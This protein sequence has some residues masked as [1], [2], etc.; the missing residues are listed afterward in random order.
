MQEAFGLQTELLTVSFIVHNDFSHIGAALDSLYQTTTM[1]M[2]VYLTINSGA[3]AEVE[4]IRAT[5]PQVQ[6]R[7]NAQPIGFAANHNAIMRLARTPF[8][9]LVNDDVTFQPQALDRLVGYLEAHADAGLVGPRVLN[10]DGSMQLSTFSDPA[11][12]RMLFH[13]SGLGKFT[14]HGG[15]FR[16]FLQR[17]GIARLLRV[18]SLNREPTTRDVPVI[19]GVCMVARR[20]AFLQAG[21]MDEVT[22]VYGEEMGWHW[23]LR[24]HG[25]RVV[26]LPSACVTHHNLS[27]DLSGWKLTEYRKSVLAYFVQY[28]PAWQAFV[29]RL[30]IVLTHLLAALVNMPFRR[31]AARTHWQTVRMALTWKLAH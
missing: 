6:T 27:Q 15:V 31:D 12:L 7:I 11:L 25:W 30:S 22:R 5:Y 19:V 14:A 1:P 10:P 2:Q 23:R 8:V 21:L 16:L 13:I 18:E 17:T 9:A 29:I 20:E 28:R 3:E 24:Q 4:R 26:F